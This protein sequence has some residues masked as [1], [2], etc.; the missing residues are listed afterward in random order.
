MQSRPSAPLPGLRQLLTQAHLRLIAF[1]VLLAA[2]TLALS[3]GL[4]IRA[5]VQHELVLTARTVAYTIEPAVVFEDRGQILEGMISVGAVPSVERMVVTDPAGT[6]LGSWQSEHDAAPGWLVAWA[7]SLIW[8]A[9]ARAEVIR[10]G[11]IIARIE[12]HGNAEGILRFLLS[13]AII[14]LCCVGLT[15]LAVRIL[16]RRL[17]NGLIAPLEHVAAVA[18]A[19]RKERAFEK[20]VPASGIA[21]IDRFAQDFNALL[22]ELQGWHAG[23]SAQNAELQHRANS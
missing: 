7:N 17:Q 19:V 15:V 10:D 20:R 1:A 18:R 12:V 2:S 8:D 4:V 9:P 3:G 22:A 21:E 11:R 6:V 14:A 16:A 23:M 13:G 5:Y